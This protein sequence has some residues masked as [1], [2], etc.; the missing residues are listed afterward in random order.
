MEGSRSSRASA[1]TS[2][3]GEPGKLTIRCG[4]W[5]V[6]APR[7][8]LGR[9]H[10]DEGAAMRRLR[11]NKKSLTIKTHTREVREQDTNASPVGDRRR[12]R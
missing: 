12:G 7:V 2:V 11:R 4:A 3:A 10:G 9:E 1:F 6:D 8:D 5:W